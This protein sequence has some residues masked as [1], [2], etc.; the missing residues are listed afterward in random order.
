MNQIKIKGTITRILDSNSFI[1]ELQQESS[2]LRWNISASTELILGDLVELLG[3][4]ETEKEYED[5]D[6]YL[7][8]SSR[9]LSVVCEWVDIL[10]SGTGDLVD[11]TW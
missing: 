9:Y 8:E 5:R 10:E 1:Y 6:D 2:I 4:V 11:I 7:I 3:E